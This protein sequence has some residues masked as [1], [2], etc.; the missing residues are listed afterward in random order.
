MFG[1]NGFLLG[2]E[3]FASEHELASTLVHESY[4]LATSRASSGVHGALASDETGAAFG[5]AN[6]T[7]RYVMGGR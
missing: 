3:A 2:P 4:R 6:K 5:F 1:E 7:A